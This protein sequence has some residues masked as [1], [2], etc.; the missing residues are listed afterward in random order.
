[1]AAK[2]HKWG[3]TAGVIAVLIVLAAVGFSVYSI[4]HRPAAMPFQHFT[5]TQ[6]TN[7][8]RAAQ[9]AISP[10]GK[11]VL[12]VTDDNGM[13]SLWLRNVPTGSDTQV[14]APSA[15]TY[16]SLT[17]SPDGNFIYFRKSVNANVYNLYR[18]PVLGGTPQTI[19]RDVDSDVAFSPDGQHIAYVRQNDPE[20]GK[21]RL[22]MAS[23]DGSDEKVL[24]IGPELG[25]PGFLAWSPNGNEIIYSVSIADQGLGTIEVFDVRTGKTHRFVALKG[26]FSYELKWSPDGRTLFAMYSQRGANYLGSQIGFFSGTGGDIEPITRDTNSY[27]G[28]TLSADGR[29]L[30]TVLTKRFANI[31]IL[32]A[33]G[34]DSGEAKPILSQANHIIAFNWTADGNL[35]ATDSGRLLKLGV[36]GKNQTQLLADSSAAMWTPSACGAN[37][38]VFTWLFHGDAPWANIWRTNTDGSSPLKLTNGHYEYLPTCSPDQKW[39]YYTEFSDRGLWRVPLDGSGK[40]ETVP[41]SSIPNALAGAPVI[42]PD[43]KTLARLADLLIPETQEY[44]TKIVLSNLESSTA[45]RTLDVSGQLGG[46]GDT[47]WAGVGFTP[48][49]KAVAHII[50]EN[51]VDNVWVQPL[52]G[53]AGHRI[54]NFTSEQIDSFHWSPDGKKLGILRGHSDSD[55]VLLQESKQ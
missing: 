37:Y 27:A 25:A 20:V 48:D 4:F 39:V 15:G 16:Q 46:S 36:D 19:A 53:S 10:D 55:V 31:Y 23:M 47:P 21:Y 26:K 32:A 43:G 34:N 45:V 35:L 12:S 11:Y 41:G 24:Q 6:I 52:D 18:A 40:P 22:L 54:T 3:V 44:Q 17:F 14:I 51:G 13:K 38:F 9:A 1:L 50:R 8:G 42:S 5:I 29:T 28:L 30:A 7:S 33:A 2:Q 49:G